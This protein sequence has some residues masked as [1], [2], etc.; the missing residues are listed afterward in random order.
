MTSRA[1]LVAVGIA[2]VVNIL[3][4]PILMKRFSKKQIYGFSVIIVAVLFL[5]GYL[6]SDSNRGGYFMFTGWQVGIVMTFA[7]IYA[8][9][10]D[11]VDFGE[12]KSGVSAPGTVNTVITIHSE[13]HH[14]YRN[15]CHQCYS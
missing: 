3:L 10:P 9:V 7:C 2:I 1:S 6:L 12:W 15:I 14:G 5:I 4:L 13:S 11:A 8:T